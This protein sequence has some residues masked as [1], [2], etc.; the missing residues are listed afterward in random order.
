MAG[1]WVR[2]RWEER[3]FPQAFKGTM[4]QLMRAVQEDAE[5][6]ISGRTTLGT[7]ALVEAAYRSAARGPG[8]R[9]LRDD[10]WRCTLTAQ[11]RLDGRVAIVTGGGGGLGAGICRALAA[12]GAAVRPWPAANQS[13]ATSSRPMSAARR[14]AIAVEADIA[15]RGSVEA[16]AERVVRELGGVDVLVNNAAIYPRRAWTEITEAEWDEVLAT[17]LKGY[18]L[19]ARAGYPS[20][21]A[22]GH[23]RIINVS[24]DHLLRRPA[25]CCS[26]TSSSKGGIVGFTRALAREVGPEGITVNT[27]SPGAFPTDAEKIHPDPEELQQLDPRPAEHQAPRHAGGHRQ[28]RRLPRERRVA[29][30]ITGQIDPDRRRLGDALT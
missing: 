2:P 30:F 19:C 10:A 20:M 12:A 23:G 24:L 21:K 17:N 8:G 9:A 27:I 6:E 7:M 18:F 15:D 25:R 4:G 26:I 29:S 14:Q 16:M 1:E 11:F 5:P 3:W 28:P 22:R 13:R